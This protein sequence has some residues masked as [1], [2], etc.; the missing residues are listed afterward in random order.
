M[1][2]NKNDM[3][4]VSI[5]PYADIVPFFRWIHDLNRIYD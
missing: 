4:Q 1:H 2:V 5:K 3:I